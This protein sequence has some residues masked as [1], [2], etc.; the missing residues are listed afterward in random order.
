MSDIKNELDAIMISAL[1]GGGETSSF[2]NDIMQ[3]IVG[4]NRKRKARKT[5]ENIAI[6]SYIGVTTIL[7]MVMLTLTDEFRVNKPI[8][9]TPWFDTESLREYYTLMITCILLSFISLVIYC[10]KLRP[11]AKAKN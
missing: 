7:L 8:L 11:W 1:K 10:L 4:I 3:K 5:K 9:K 6:L 2:H